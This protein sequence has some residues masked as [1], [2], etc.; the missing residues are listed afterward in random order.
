MHNLENARVEIA[1]AVVRLFALSADVLTFGTTTLDH[2]Q[3][4]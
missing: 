2:F 1:R 4:E 3:I